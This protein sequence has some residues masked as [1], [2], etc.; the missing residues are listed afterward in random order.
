VGPFFLE[1]G[2]ARLTKLSKDQVAGDVRDLYT[3]VG[4]QRGNV[5]NMFRIYAH[6][7]E[8]LKTMVAHLQAITNTGTV[9]VK[10]KELVATLVSRINDCAY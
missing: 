8:I 1:Y 4:E 2:M 5:P 9:P 6:R 3:R 10:T 7:P